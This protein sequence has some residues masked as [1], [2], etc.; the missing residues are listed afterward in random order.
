[1]GVL[2][3]PSGRYLSEWWYVLWSAAEPIELA[4]AQ[5]LHAK[6][7]IPFELFNLFVPAIDAFKLRVRGRFRF[8]QIRRRRAVRE[9]RRQWVRFHAV[10]LNQ[11]NHCERNLYSRLL[12]VSGAGWSIQ[13]R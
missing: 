4:P 12:H 11:A 1:M 5:S 6:H 13:L 3:F 8:K 10:S 2:V 9:Y 7:E